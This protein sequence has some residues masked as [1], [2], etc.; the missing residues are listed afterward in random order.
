MPM[1][2]DEPQTPPGRASRRGT[3][4][5]KRTSMFVDTIR[6]AMMEAD[7]R[8][9]KDPATKAKLGAVARWLLSIACCAHS[10]ELHDSIMDLA[11]VS[12]ISQRLNLSRVVYV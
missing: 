1:L 3:G 12:R 4:S 9:G 2:P 8:S 10:E 7:E 6:A 11:E 5:S